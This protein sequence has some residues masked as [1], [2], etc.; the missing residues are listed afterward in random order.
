MQPPAYPPPPGA[1]QPQPAYGA[2][3]PPPARPG[4][5]TAAAVLLI[6]LGIVPCIFA[7]LAFVGAGFLSRADNTSNEFAG[8]GDA[9]ARVAV[10]FG[11]LALAYGVVKLTAGIKVLGRSNAWRVTGIVFASLGA[12]FWVLGL[13]GSLNPNDNTVGAR[14]SSNAGGIVVSLVLLVANVVVIVL[15]G[16][17]GAWFRGTS[18]RSAPVGQFTA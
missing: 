13:I 14:S 16:R 10:V 1:P 15:L 6:I 2:A 12:A 8:L 7:V 5:V 9:I 18:A 3:G 4:G 11:V 17:A